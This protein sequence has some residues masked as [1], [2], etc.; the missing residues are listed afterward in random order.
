M[1]STYGMHL[2]MRL[3]GIERRGALEGAAAVK[4][5]VV[6][7]VDRI[8][9]RV[10]AG[11]LVGEEQG[12]ADKRG[13]SCVVIVYESHIAIHTYPDLG[14]AFLDIFSCREFEVSDVKAVLTE[15]LGDF[16]ICES[17]FFDRGVHWSPNV[18]RELAGWLAHR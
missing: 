14:E 17:N 8:G 5:L 1:T 13:W 6:D 3:N 12:P 9:M 2:T 10:L 15:K 7:L 4:E 11:P 16:A 18:Q